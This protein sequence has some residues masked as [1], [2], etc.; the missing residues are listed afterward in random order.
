[1]EVEVAYAKADEQ[2]IIPVSVEEDATLADA[3]ALSGI[4]A[5]FPEIDLKQ[6]QVGVFGKLGKLSQKTAAGDRVE[7]YRPLQQHPMDARRQRAA[8]Q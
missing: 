4:L 7:I 8:G 1:M 3:I 2:L 6:N 5:R